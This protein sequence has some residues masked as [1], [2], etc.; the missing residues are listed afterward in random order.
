MKFEEQLFHAAIYAIG[1]SYILD[2]L[3]TM[4][5]YVVS[6]YMP[7]HFNWSLSLNDVPSWVLIWRAA[8]RLEEQYI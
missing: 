4:D 2:R 8:R 3:M 7:E 1:L 6:K 5:F